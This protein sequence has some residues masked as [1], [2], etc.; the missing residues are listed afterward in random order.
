MKSQS[1]SKPKILVV[2]DEPDNLDLLYRTFYR[3]YQVLKASSG[4]AALELLQQEGEV[5]VIISDQR[6]PMMSGTEFLSLTATQYPDIIRIILTGYTDVEDLVE[7]INAGKVFKYVTKP[8]EAEELK[9]VV[10]QALDTHNVLKT[11]TRELTR[12]L[13]QE[14]LLN[15]VTNTIRSALDYR[16]ILQAIVDTVG[17]MLEVDVCLLRPFQDGQLVDENFIYQRGIS[18][19]SLE[20]GGL[21]GDKGD[22][23]DYSFS[24]SGRASS[25]NAFNPPQAPDSPSPPLPMSS[26]SP[27]LPLPPSPHPA[28]LAQTVWEIREVQVIHDVA[29]DERIQGDTAELLSRSAAFATAKICSS[30]VV[31]LICRQELMAVLALHQC[32]QPRVWSE[33]EVQLVVM[34]AN[35]AALALSQA[36]AYEQV[37]A[38]A[39]RESLINTI[40]SAIRSSLD[41]EDIFAAITQQLGQ[42]L[43]VDGCV[44][45]LWTE[46]DEY[47]KCVGLYESS[48]SSQDS[49]KLDHPWETGS[50]NYIENQELPQSMSPIQGNPILQEMLRTQEPV[51][52]TDMSHCLPEIKGF[53][54]PLRGKARSLMVVPLLADGKSIGS[55]TLR[56]DSRAR[57]WLVTEI[58]L[59]SSVAAQAAIAVQ[60]SH[61][62]Q[63]TR[64]QAERLLELDKQKTEFFQNISHEFRTPITLIQGP[65]ESA[66]ATKEGLSYAQSA[67]AL[68]NSRRLLRLVN[69]LLD[70]QRLDAKR[71]Q[72]SFRPCDLVE[73]VNQIVESFRPYCEKKGLN[74]ITELEPSPTVYLDMEKFDKVLYNLLSNAMKFTSVGGNITVR[75]QSQGDRCRL[76]VQDTGIG[77]VTEQIPYLFERFRQAEGTEN[78]SYEGSGLGLALVKELMEMHRGKVTVESVYGKGTTFSLW[79]LAGTAHL[80][81]EQLLEA[82]CEVNTSRA[83]VELADL[84]LQS[85]DE[86]EN[87]QKDLL[88]NVNTQENE[89]KI[90]E[91]ILVVDDNPDLRT[92]V[93]EILR[94]NGYRVHTARNGSEGFIMAKEIIPR[95]IVSDLMMPL[96]S[97]ME[98]IRMIRNEE[99]LKGIPIILLTAKVDEETRIEGTEKG[100]DA[101]L[102]KPFNDRELLAEVRNL[103]ALKENERRVLELNTY[104]TESVLK[105]FLPSA[106]VQKAATGDL[107]LDLRPEPRLITVLFSDIVGFTQLS[108]TLRSRRVAEL[109]N[110][111]LESMTKV[112]FENGGTIDK[113]MGDAILALYGAPEELTPNEQVRRSINTARGM[114]R[115]LS[116]LN[117]RWREQGI[118]DSDGR[119]GL[120]F[121]CG[122]H[123]GTAV[124]G[125]F[126]SA[127]R[128]DYTAIGPSVNI[129]SRLQVAALPGTILV[130]AAVADYLDEDEIIK[131]SPLELKGIDETVLT[132]VVKAEI[133]VRS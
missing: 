48:Y 18:Q 105:R 63:K 43:Q 20:R 81:T 122:I 9:T 57:K 58:Q 84:E 50:H 7:A 102:A 92:Y 100:A 74:L 11:R 51:V 44:L 53:D 85:I 42:A 34:V 79:L 6:M 90:G 133:T 121:R 36:Y 93:S 56:Q 55:I 91:S 129:A 5:S 62:Y 125:M 16:Q 41:P 107:V 24:S 106:L 78:R 37:R 64:E 54:L 47:V 49:F 67:I 59:A 26:L 73:F 101:Y 66:V 86:F 31:P 2:D 71:M 88:N 108:N 23:G 83:N 82:P 39:K 98:M 103:L 52:I 8:W 61:L 95:L 97:G 65:L 127:E 4:L 3:D 21:L 87:I 124:V 69:Q 76:Q 89:L 110:E 19:D 113:F 120:Q 12:T 32:K 27:T 131:G 118:F 40:T 15:S 130:S 77:I 38:L 132:F 80:P 46:E 99:K 128:A 33:D 115:S 104:L 123:Q 116:L 13:R 60:Q 30:L 35:Q 68:R 29:I 72:P 75:L 126:G 112:V 114:H 14:S 1:N 17:H 109:L 94:A 45:S 96:V 119:N 22:K 25:F 10:R 70:L 117:Q 111:Y 28:L